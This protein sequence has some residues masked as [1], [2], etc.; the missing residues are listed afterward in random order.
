MDSFV[1]SFK[2]F[3]F[4]AVDLGWAG[5]C[6][7]A[8]RRVLSQRGGRVGVVDLARLHGTGA[9]GLLLLGLEQDF[10]LLRGV[11]LL[12]LR[13]VV[14]QREV[15]GRLGPPQLHEGSVVGLGCLRLVVVEP[16]I[17][18]PG[19]RH[20]DACF[21]TPVRMPGH[22]AVLAR[23]PRKALRLPAHRHHQLLEGDGV[24]VL[25]QLRV[26][27]HVEVRLHLLALAL[28]GGDVICLGRVL[29][30]LVAPEIHLLPG[31]PHPDVRLPAPAPAV[32]RDPPVLGRP[33]A[34]SLL[35]RWP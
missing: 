35:E 11:V 16:Q 4:C 27:A 13:V 9:S 23:P 14:R 3:Y 25:Q 24:H 28:Q 29:L 15:R 18:V 21:P 5:R 34:W 33:L 17:D 22:P 19:A 6:L 31:L 12:Q 7:D 10:L 2:F 8:P 20:A 30:Q 26:L 1:Y 32:L